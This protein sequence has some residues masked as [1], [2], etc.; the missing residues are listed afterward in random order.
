MER[1]FSARTA[2]AA[3]PSC[4]SAPCGDLS[5]RRAGSVCTCTGN[6][7]M[8]VTVGSPANASRHSVVLSLWLRS[9]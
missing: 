1:P 8:H 7:P 3:L 9:L 5:A 4:G 6:R 2:S